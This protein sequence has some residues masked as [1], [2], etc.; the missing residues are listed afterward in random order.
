MLI[1]RIFP[2]NGFGIVEIESISFGV[3]AAWGNSWVLQPKKCF[4]ILSSTEFFQAKS[5]RSTLGSQWGLNNSFLPIIGTEK[6]G[7]TSLLEAFLQFQISSGPTR[8]PVVVKLI[9]NSN[10]LE[11]K[12][13][14]EGEIDYTPINNIPEKL[15]LKTNEKKWRWSKV[16]DYPIIITIFNKNYFNIT[17]VDTPE[18]R[19]NATDSRSSEVNEMIKKYAQNRFIICME[20]STSEYC[21]M[22]SPKFLETI[23][24]TLQRTV[25]VFSKFDNRFKSF[26]NENEINNYF[27]SGIQKFSNDSFFVR[28]RSEYSNQS[29]HSYLLHNHLELLKKSIKL[30]MDE[31]KYSKYFGF[32]KIKNFLENRWIA[33]VVLAWLKYFSDYF[34]FQRK[35]SQILLH[36]SRDIEMFMMIEKKNWDLICNLL[37]IFP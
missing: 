14:F 10:E 25:F 4:M 19:M 18:I 1:T 30:G 26:K 12:C 29:F 20:Q 16:K 27:D 37:H 3:L 15:N 9:Q 11:P 8:T 34:K 33:Y 31:K 21:N 6:D 28:L 2:S 36:P 5:S 24:P 32:F 23:D 22:Q 35:L 13:L 17:L 7:K